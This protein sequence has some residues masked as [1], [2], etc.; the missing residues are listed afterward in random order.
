MK[1]RRDFSQGL[2]ILD[3]TELS[4]PNLPQKDEFGPLS[5]IFSELKTFP[6]CS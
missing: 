3:N 4:F 1:A 2:T 5:D 6:L